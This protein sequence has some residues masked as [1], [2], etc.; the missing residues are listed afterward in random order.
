GTGRDDH[1]ERPRRTLLEKDLFWLVGDEGHQLGQLM[2]GRVGD[3]LEEL[4]MPKTV[5][6]GGRHP[7]KMTGV[8]GRMQLATLGSAAQWP[9]SAVP[10]MIFRSSSEP[11]MSLSRRDFLTA[12]AATAAG[13][14]VPNL[15]KAMPV[16]TV[17][18]RSELVPKA[19]AGRPVI[20]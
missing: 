15:A 1:H 10:S 4:R 6:D 19:F 7:R 8:G 14:T 13:L 18:D 16:I 17:R 2:D 12:G 20:I 9:S 11:L 3:A 5:A